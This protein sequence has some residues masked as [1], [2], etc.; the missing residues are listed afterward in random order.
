MANR[1]LLN[2]ILEYGTRIGKSVFMAYQKS[3]NSN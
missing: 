3:V 1:F 2:L